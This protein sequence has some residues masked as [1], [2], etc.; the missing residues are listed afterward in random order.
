MTAYPWY[1]EHLAGH[2]RYCTQP[3]HSLMHYCS[4]NP[5]E[6]ATMR[7]EPSQAWLRDHD[8]S[9]H[10]EEVTTVNDKTAPGYAGPTGREL[11][12]EHWNA[13]AI[14]ELA[15][16]APEAT[17]EPPAMNELVR[18]AADLMMGGLYEPG[19]YVKSAH[20]R[21][22]CLNEDGEGGAWFYA[23]TDEEN[24]DVERVRVTITPA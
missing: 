24:T 17:A 13:R 9:T 15:E 2:A 10:P 5:A 21:A 20:M 4:A 7:G 3:Y 16:A 22:G 18:K 6:P 19:Q 12:G 14:R 23:E 11:P 1:P 8:S